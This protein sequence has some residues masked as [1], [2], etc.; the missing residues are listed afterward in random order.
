MMQFKMVLE[1]FHKLHSLIYVSQFVHDIMNYTT[2][3][4]SIESGKGRN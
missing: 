3:I 1:L 2:F 4:Y